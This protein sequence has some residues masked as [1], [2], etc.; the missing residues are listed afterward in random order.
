MNQPISTQNVN[1]S[2]KRICK[3]IG[4]KPTGGQHLL[5]HTFVTRCIEAD[6]PIDVIMHWVGHKDITTTMNTYAD[7][8]KNRSDKSF[9]K[10]TDYYGKTFIV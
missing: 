9:D 10:L 1:C 8:L 4:I 6:I 3:S 2:F 5:R 7:V